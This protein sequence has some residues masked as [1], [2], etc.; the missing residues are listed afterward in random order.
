M[1]RASRETVVA[2]LRAEGASADDTEAIV[3]ALERAALNPPQMRAWLSHPQKA[4]NVAIGIKFGHVEWRQVPTHAIE[5]GRADAVRAAAEEFAD[6][7]RDERYIS[8]T[9]LCELDAV[10]RLT[11]ADPE[12]TAMVVR[13]AGLFKAALKKEIHVYYAVQQ[14][15]SGTYDGD[16]TR[17]VDLMLD[18][19]LPAALAAVE[20]GEI[21]PV[22]LSRQDALAGYGW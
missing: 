6:A 1:A 15:L 5:R 9:M 3:A 21:D 22:A 16:P 8:R 14:V 19:R 12:R 11:H 17:F 13:L 20:S 18:D 10:R 7:S 4:Y 2:L